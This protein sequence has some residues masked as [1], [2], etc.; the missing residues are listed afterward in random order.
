[1]LNPSPELA[2]LFELIGRQ[3]PEVIDYLEALNANEIKQ[4]VAGGEDARADVTRG[5]IRM[6][7][8]L[9]QLFKGRRK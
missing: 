2:R 5:H 8:H 4:L 9:L 7:G 1:M 3:S 6:L